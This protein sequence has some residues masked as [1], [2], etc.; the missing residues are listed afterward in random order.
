MS[1]GAVPGTY[2]W[3]RA[4]H[5]CPQSRFSS[6]GRWHP[7]LSLLSCMGSMT[8]RKLAKRL[9]KEVTIRGHDTVGK[10]LCSMF[11]AGQWNGIP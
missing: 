11:F 8:I 4:L 3:Q 1:S 10:C 7:P 9:Y 6:H 5:L 2:A